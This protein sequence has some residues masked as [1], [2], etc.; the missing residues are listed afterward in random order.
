VSGVWL[1]IMHRRSD[2]ETVEVRVPGG[3][4][5]IYLFAPIWRYGC[6]GPRIALDASDA[7]E[8]AK[9]ICSLAA[10]SSLNG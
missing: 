10:V 9:D 7:G 5:R 6:A 2:A 1:L 4:I 3:Q 8:F